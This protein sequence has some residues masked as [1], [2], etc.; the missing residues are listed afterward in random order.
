MSLR[1]LSCITRAF[2]D[3]WSAGFT[4]GAEEDSETSSFG[5]DSSEGEGD[6]GNEVDAVGRSRGGKVVGR[7]TAAERRQRV[8]CSN[9]RCMASPANETFNSQKR[10][11]P[12]L[13]C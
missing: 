13:F 11:F 2:R 8:Q 9:R 6:A 7:T 3:G 10:E 12:K 4:S 5:T 1:K